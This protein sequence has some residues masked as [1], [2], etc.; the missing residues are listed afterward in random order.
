MD[1]D[2][3]MLLFSGFGVVL[4]MIGAGIFNQLRK[5]TTSVEA[6]S[7]NVA[8]IIERVNQHEKRITNLEEHEN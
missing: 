6:L 4:S 5:L 7:V 3:S 1:H 2:L 8:V